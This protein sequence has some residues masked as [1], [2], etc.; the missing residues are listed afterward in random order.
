MK[1]KIKAKVL[2][3]LKG[4]SLFSMKYPNKRYLLVA[5]STIDLTL[6]KVSKANEDFIKEVKEEIMDLS[7]L[8]KNAHLD[9]KAEFVTILEDKIDK[10]A[11]EYKQKLG[12]EVLK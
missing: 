3:A 10:L 2:K 8:Q 12:I 9:F 11:K 4:T 5:D 7:I 6:A 1:N